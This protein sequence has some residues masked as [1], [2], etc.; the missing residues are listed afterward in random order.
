[1]EIIEALLAGFGFYNLV[2]VIIE[3]IANKLD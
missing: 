1:M 2:M 3:Y